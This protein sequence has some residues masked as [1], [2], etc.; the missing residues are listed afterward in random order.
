VGYAF[1]NMTAPRH[2]LPLVERFDGRR[3]ERFNSE[4][5]CAISYA[6]IQGRAALISHFQNSSL[7]HEDKRCRPVLFITEGP[8]AGEQEPFPVGAAVR[9]RQPHAGGGGSGSG[10]GSGGGG[11]GSGGGGGL[12]ERGGGGS[13]SSL[14]RAGG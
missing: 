14:S 2:I 10:S 9:P 13:G 6:R 8:H 12:P 7:M 5:V 11:G 4:K 1:I 3:W